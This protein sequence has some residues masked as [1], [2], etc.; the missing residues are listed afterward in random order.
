MFDLKSQKYIYEFF[1]AYD[2][3]YIEKKNMFV[4]SLTLN[5]KIKCTVKLGH[6]AL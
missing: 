6:R 2:I 5:R 1:Y 4:R 3:H